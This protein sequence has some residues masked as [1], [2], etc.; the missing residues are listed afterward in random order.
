M[1]VDRADG[2]EELFSDFLV[3]VAEGEQL[4]DVSL[5]LGQRLEGW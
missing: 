2:D 1:R 4:Q 5:S 3:R